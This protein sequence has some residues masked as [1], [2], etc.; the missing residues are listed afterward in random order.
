MAR[1]AIKA[2]STERVLRLVAIFHTDCDR[3]NN[4]T[5]TFGAFVGKLNVLEANHP[6]PRVVVPIRP[7]VREERRHPTPEEYAESQRI[8]A[9]V[10]AAEAERDKARGAQARADARQRSIA[11]YGLAEVEA[12]EKRQREAQERHAAAVAAGTA[13]KIA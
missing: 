8:L 9:E 11:R 3:Q 1:A 5:R 10:K 2:R 6:M 12:V 13:V 7:L 4:P